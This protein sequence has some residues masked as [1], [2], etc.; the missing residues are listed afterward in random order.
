MLEFRNETSRCGI[1]ISENDGEKE[2]RGKVG[3]VGRLRLELCNNRIITYEGL[4]EN[5]L[6]A[7]VTSLITGVLRL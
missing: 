2:R 5:E 3:N 7:V 6:A 1:E 4:Q